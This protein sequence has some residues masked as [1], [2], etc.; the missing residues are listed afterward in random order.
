MFVDRVKISVKAGK[1]GDGIVAY[2]REK[3]VPLGGPAGGDGGKGGSVIFEVD[4]NKSTLL[5]LRYN[6]KIKA[7]DGERG[8]T[9]KMHGADGEDIIVKVPLGTIVKD[10]SDNHVIA[11]LTY[12]NQRAVIAKGGAGGRG[13]YHFM[14]SRNTAPDFSENGE[15]GEEKEILVELKLLADAG[16]VG[17]PSVGKST[18]LSVV[19]AAR[20]EIADYHFTTLVPNLGVVKVKDGRSFVLADLP[21]LIEGAAEGKGLGH[22]FLRHIERCRVILHVIDMGSEEGR[23][24][25]NDYEIINKEL[26][27]YQYRL[28]ERPQIVVA[29][30]M[31]LDD[32]EANLERFRAKY[33]D[34]KVFPVITLIEEGLDPVLYEVANLL[35]TTPTFPLF[36]EDEEGVVYRYEPEDNEI[37]VRNLGNNQWRLYGTRI[38]RMFRRTKFET[39]DD[40]FRFGTTLRKMGVDD[41]LREAGALDGDTVFI[42]DYSFEFVESYD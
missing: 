39:E 15:I 42:L 11:D 7:Q 26:G 6:K 18:F 5:D 38:E 33:P 31:D 3:Y 34:I 21:G 13:N 25:L 23:D 8:K 2:R 1:G 14:N 29:N 32:A 41:L 30:K 24:P 27:A 4:S 20:P 12:Q 16:L 9:K 17:F 35:E 19:S 40:V 37:H 36:D 22:E 28:L 10:L